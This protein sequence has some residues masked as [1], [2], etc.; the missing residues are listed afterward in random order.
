MYK[1]ILI[2]LALPMLAAPALAQESGTLNAVIANGIV[3][4]AQGY[5]IPIEYNEDGTYT[6]SLGGTDF[7]GEW[8]IDGK[9]LCTTSDMSPTET[10]TE[11]PD[12][13]GPGDAFEVTNP[14]LGKVGIKINDAG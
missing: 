13:K 12:D 10:C 2:S 14:A 9:S 1:T 8:R 4:D 5:S 7:N 6:G 11:Y 3:I